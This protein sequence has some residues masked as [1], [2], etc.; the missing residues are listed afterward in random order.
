MLRSCDARGR[1]H[2][3]FTALEVVLAVMVL[4]LAL[5]PMVR[6]LQDTGREAGF[7]E[8]YLLA[9]ARLQSI[10]DAAEGAGWI[11]L[12]RTV[13]T[14]EMAIPLSAGDAPEELVG[15]SPDVYAE[16]L[17]A[18]RLEDGLIRLQ[19]RVRWLPSGLGAGRHVSEAA[20]VR[21]LRRADGGWSRPF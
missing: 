9:H 5:V 19:A 3:G 17:F 2:A 14:S 10:L 13:T 16:I 4:G 15:P 21:I 6:S 12:P 1:T 18:E 7:S 11:S 20:S 8:S